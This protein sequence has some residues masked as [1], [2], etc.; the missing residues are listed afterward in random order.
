MRHLLDKF[1]T[2]FALV[3]PGTGLD[4]NVNNKLVAVV[5]IHAAD[6]EVDVLML[7]GICFKQPLELVNMYLPSLLLLLLIVFLKQPPVLC[8]ILL[9]LATCFPIC[10]CV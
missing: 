2:N 1:F 6:M 9:N 7:D 8:H 4:G 3:S 10:I 5:V